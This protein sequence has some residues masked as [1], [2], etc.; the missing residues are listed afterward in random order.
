MLNKKNLPL[1]SIVMNCHNGEKYL[2]DALKS[3]FNQTYQNWELIFWDNLSTDKSSVILKR[4]KDQRIKYFLAEKFE[5]LYKARN[6]ALE[7]TFGEYICFLDTDDLWNENFI[8]KHLNTIKD[9]NCNISYSKYFIQNEINKKKYINENSSLPSGLITMHLLKN[10]TIGISATLS[11]KKIFQKYKFNP[12]YNI[13]GDFDFFLKLSL[14]E[15]FHPLQEPLLT[16]RHHP[17]NFTNNNYDTYV[18]ELKNWIKINKSEFKTIN[19]FNHLK[20]NILKLKIKKYLRYFFN[21]S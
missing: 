18:D 3:I 16:Y 7:K 20:I 5:K 17:N 19:N 6:L 15:S 21:N 4:Y 2:E 8:E 12:N 10:Y 14:S 11:N 9:S 1:V 13:I